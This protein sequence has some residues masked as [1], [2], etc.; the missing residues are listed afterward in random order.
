MP[1]NA[2]PPF[3]VRRPRI[4]P[5][6]IATTGPVCAAEIAAP[7]NTNAHRTSFGPIGTIVT[8]SLHLSFRG[9]DRLK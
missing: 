7:A 8:E 3:A 1:L 4:W 2:A 5:P 9:R 6:V